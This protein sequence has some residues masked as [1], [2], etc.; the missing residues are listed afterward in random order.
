MTLPTAPSFMFPPMN[1]NFGQP[2]HPVTS[3]AG[4][5]VIKTTQ[6]RPMNLS[7]NAAAIQQVGVCTAQ[8]GPASQL[9][10]SQNI[11]NTAQSSSS[12]FGSST[13]SPA[14][15]GP[16]R[17]KSPSTS[18][19]F[20]QSVHGLSSSDRLVQKRLSVRA[21]RHALLCGRNINKPLQPLKIP[22]VAS[23]SVGTSYHG[24]QEV[25]KV[26]AKVFFA[27]VLVGKYTVGNPKLRK[28]PPLYPK[29]DQYG[30]CYDSCVD[31]EADPK[32]FVIFDS[33]QAY[34]EY[35]LEYIYSSDRPF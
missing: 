6:Y 1:V 26:K 28:P 14:Q 29:S 23:T 20:M 18:T 3:H 33:T 32:I 7:H 11:T 21:R 10:S 35:L 13:A 31:N 25:E 27:R 19:S 4:I 8:A 30:K 15:P 24:Q 34:P 12:Q 22:S 16:S 17:S 5:S 2:L 9:G